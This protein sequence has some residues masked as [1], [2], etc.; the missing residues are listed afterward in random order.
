[1]DAL[2]KKLLNNLKCPV[3]KAPIDILKYTKPWNFGCAYEFDHYRLRLNDGYI[4]AEQTS[5]YDISHKY[6]ILKEY[7]DFQIKTTIHI[8][9]AD[10]EGRVGFSFVDKKVTTDIDLFD[11]KNFDSKKALN[12]IKTYLLFQ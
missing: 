4:S 5:I 3:C 7:K 8:Y 2:T 12:R 11:F 9:N 6:V 1:M 10:P